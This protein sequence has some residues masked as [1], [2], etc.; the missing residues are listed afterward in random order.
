M[1]AL[2]RRG[3]CCCGDGGDGGG[4]R[5]PIDVRNLH[6][7]VV[8]RRLPWQPEGELVHAARLQRFTVEKKT[9]GAAG[10]S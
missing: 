4:T 7:R 2:L 3:R 1:A 6:L 5:L 10:V 8:A 9:A